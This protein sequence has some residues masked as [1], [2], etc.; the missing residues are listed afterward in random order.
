MLFNFIFY[1]LFYRY[2]LQGLGQSIIPTF[3][4]IME[5]VMRAAAGLFLVDAFGYIG[6]CWANP[7][8]WIGSCVPLMITF[9]ITRKS[10]LKKYYE[11]KL[12]VDLHKKKFSYIYIN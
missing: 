12:S 3:A 4:G 10:L 5:L 9:Y 2:T 1:Y 8:A 7:M 11:H 6:A